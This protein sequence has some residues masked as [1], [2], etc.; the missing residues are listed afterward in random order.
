M[1][2]NRKKSFKN[3]ERKYYSQEKEKK[4]F[5]KFDKKK[6]NVILMHND[7][8]LFFIYIS[9]LQKSCKEYDSSKIMF[10][11]L[12]FSTILLSTFAYGTFS[13]M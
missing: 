5:P 13:F 3:K 11:T 4:G 2:S 6:L 9:D 8:T 10:K 7:V 12:F 1:L